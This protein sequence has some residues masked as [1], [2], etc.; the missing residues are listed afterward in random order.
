MDPHLEKIDRLLEK[1][2]KEDTFKFWLKLKERISNSCWDKPASSTGKYHQK[3]E[4]RI[5][6]VSEHTYEMLYAAIKISSMF[7]GLVNKE[8]IFLSIVLHDAYKYGLVKSC[9]FTE[10]RHGEII[11]ETIEKNRKIYKSILTEKEITLL[12]NAVKYHDGKFSPIA[13]KDSF[14]RSF[15]TP[16]TMFLHTLD[17][18]SSRNLIKVIEE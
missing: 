12:E 18:M 3:E 9:Q 17:M 10:E 13:K 6:S 15:L 11:A 16:E 2:L 1:N 5:P 4:G 7:E 14:D 8:L